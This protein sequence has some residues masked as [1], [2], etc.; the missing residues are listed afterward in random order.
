MNAKRGNLQMKRAGLVAATLL[1]I[2][3]AVSALSQ[4]QIKLFKIV[5][6]KDEIVI[7]LTSDE[8][9][10]FG[11]STDLDNLAQHLAAAGEMTVWQYAV[12]KDPGGTL[13]QAP[14]RRIAI[15]RSDTLRIEPYA[16]PL[17]VASP[18][19]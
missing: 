13:Q 10:T 16:S 11:P 19:K 7:G 15:F 3:P 18:E 12:R 4:D 8:L 9:R 1:A 17:P 14:L 2:W 5:S 6:Q